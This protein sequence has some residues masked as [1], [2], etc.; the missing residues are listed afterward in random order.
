MLNGLPDRGLAPGTIRYARTVLG[1]A[2]KDAVSWGYLRVNPAADVKAPKGGE[3]R[4]AYAL[5]PDEARARVEAALQDPEDLV[6]VF[7]LMT[8][9]RPEEYLGLP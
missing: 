1:M 6:F 2:S 9:L 8:G 3:G 4:V 7:A 5:K